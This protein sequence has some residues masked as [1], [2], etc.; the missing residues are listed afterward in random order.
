MP[1]PENGVALGTRAQ[2][3]ASN[4]QALEILE[5]RGCP[6]FHWAIC[7]W[8]FRFTP[9]ISSAMGLLISDLFGRAPHTPRQ[10][11]RFGAV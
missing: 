7:R 9:E 2:T 1:F 8:Q 4:L 11:L 6:S 3:L 10:G 5:V